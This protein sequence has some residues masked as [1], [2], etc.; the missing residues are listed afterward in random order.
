L[1][2][3]VVREVITMRCA[4]LLAALLVAPPSLLRADTLILDGIEQAA[5]TAGDRPHRGMTMQQV[6]KRWG[7]PA[8]KVDAVGKPP[9]TRWEYDGFTVYFEHEHVVHTVLHHPA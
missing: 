6:T 3:A 5:P 9:I 8:Q 2:T 1:E 4:L 7:E